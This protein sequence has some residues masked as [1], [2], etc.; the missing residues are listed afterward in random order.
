[1][2]GS[3]HRETAF[4]KAHTAGKVIFFLDLYPDTVFYALAQS[5]LQWFQVSPIHPSLNGANEIANESAHA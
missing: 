5:T 4:T 1:M 3:L 2:V